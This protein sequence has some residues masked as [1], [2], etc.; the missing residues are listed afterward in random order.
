MQNAY[1][2]FAIAG[3]L[4]ILFHLFAI[5]LP[6]VKRRAYVANHDFSVAEYFKD[7]W[8]AIVASFV[9][10]AGWIVC[11]D[12]LIGYKPEVARMAKFLFFF[13]GVT[14]NSVSMALISIATNKVMAV[15]DI[16][17]NIADGV[18][19]PVT[20]GNKKG[21]AEIMKEKGLE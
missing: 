7:D 20:A 14:N 8:I 6:S 11:Y 4:G 19:P 3:T 18:T 5:K 9:G 15:I 16:K 10:L 13:V 21:V 2:N 17:T 1:I 12:E